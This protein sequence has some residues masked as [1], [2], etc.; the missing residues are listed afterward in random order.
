MQEAA[1]ARHGVASLRALPAQE[2]LVPRQ[3]GAAQEYVRCPVSHTTRSAAPLFRFSGFWS[4]LSLLL[5]R[6]RDLHPVRRRQVVPMRGR[7]RAVGDPRWVPRPA[8]ADADA[9]SAEPE[10]MRGGGCSAAAP[11][12]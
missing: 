2:A 4:F 11:P 6:E 9:A 5:R 10:A 7:A 1:K 3:R 12:E 8:D